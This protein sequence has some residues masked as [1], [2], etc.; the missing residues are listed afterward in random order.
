MARGVILA[1]GVLLGSVPATA[2]GVDFTLVNGAG[3]GLSGL[4]IRRTGTSDWRGLGQ[5]LSDGARTTVAFND[6]DC[7]FDLKATVGGA[8]AVWRGVNL[9]EVKTVTLRRSA[10]GATFVDYD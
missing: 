7:A 6:P 9:C 1:L 2:S 8:E 10:A 4:S 3:A 5:A